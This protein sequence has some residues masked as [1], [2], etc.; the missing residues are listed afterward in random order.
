[1]KSRI[2]KTLYTLMLMAGL[3][4]GAVHAEIAWH[5]EDEFTRDEQ[6]GLKSWITDT[7]SALENLVAPFPFDIN[8]HFYRLAD[9]GEPVPWANTRR[10]RRQ[11]ISFYV[12][13]AF[14][15]RAFYADWTAPHE[16]SH[17]LIP[18]LGEANSWFAEGFAS[19]FQYQVMR[20]MGEMDAAGITVAYRERMARARSSFPLS[21]TPLAG[22]A[23]ELRRSGDY[24]TY[25]WGGAVYFLRADTTLRQG[26]S[27]GLSRLVGEYL[28][29][30]RMRD[31]R[32]AGLVQEF[33][34]IAGVA[35]FSELLHE[36]R[37]RPGFPEYLEALEQLE[38]QLKSQPAARH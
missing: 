33:D 4:A 17:L 15:R 29:C 30:C 19:Y 31:T 22:A 14:P 21:D 12:D 13:P 28:A 10:G 8:I 24:P 26:D 23:R 9:R 37:E 1:M 5:W 7:V 2:V 32:L 16:L 35:L 20:H 38:I 3:G 18:Y 27:G 6:N 25:Y 36:F 11:G 34:R